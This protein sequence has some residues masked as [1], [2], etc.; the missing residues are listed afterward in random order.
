MRKAL[1]SIP[2]TTKKEHSKLRYIIPDIHLTWFVFFFLK[3]VLRT[4]YLDPDKLVQGHRQN[5]G[6]PS[7]SKWCQQ[8]KAHVQHGPLSLLLST[9]Q[10][11]CTYFS[12]TLFTTVPCTPQ[13]CDVIS[14]SPSADLLITSW[15]TKSPQLF[16]HNYMTTALERTGK[17]RNLRSSTLI[18]Q[19]YIKKLKSRSNGIYLTKAKDL[20]K[21]RVKGPIP[22]D[23]PTGLQLSEVSLS[24]SSSPKFH[25]S[26]CPPLHHTAL[27]LPNN[28]Y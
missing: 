6:V 5:L 4:L 8:E 9:A 19:F 2:L 12:A 25:S 16:H 18:S 10:R 11:S 13:L 17:V 24:S 14:A 22:R 20:V 23:L 27:T 1:S 26:S 3:L 15:V 28:I 21:D 7:E